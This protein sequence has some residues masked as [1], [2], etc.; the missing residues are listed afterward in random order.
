MRIKGPKL[1]FTEE[2][3]DNILLYA[4]LILLITQFFLPTCHFNAGRFKSLVWNSQ[5]YICRV[6]H[7]VAEAN[8][9]RLHSQASETLTVYHN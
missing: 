4:R 2:K 8:E 7:V 5:T 1:Q 9:R 3:V 6:S